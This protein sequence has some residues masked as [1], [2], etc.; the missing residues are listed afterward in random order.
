MIR[1]YNFG[2]FI[3]NSSWIT[4]WLLEFYIFQKWSRL[5]G[6][7]RN[8]KKQSI[9]PNKTNNTWSESH[10]FQ[11]WSRLCG[12]DKNLTTSNSDH[13]YAVGSGIAKTIIP[14][15]QN[16]QHVIRIEWD[17]HLSRKLVRRCSNLAQLQ[18][19]CSTNW[20]ASV[21]KKCMVWIRHRLCSKEMHG[22]NK[23]STL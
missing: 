7:E 17:K 10:I 11:F 5:C 15:Q 19:S 12:R 22:L 9:P 21:V 14:A 16:K 6:K 1:A 20:Y 13:V 3:H 4:T 8:R 18:Y 2:I 23:T